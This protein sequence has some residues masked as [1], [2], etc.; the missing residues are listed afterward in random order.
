MGQAGRQFAEAHY[1]M[2]IVGQRTYAAY[3]QVALTGVS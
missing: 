3:R 1:R 2:D